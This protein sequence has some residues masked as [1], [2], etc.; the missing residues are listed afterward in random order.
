LPKRL[1]E[2]AGQRRRFGYQRLAI[3]LRREG[4]VVNLK[5]IWRL[6]RPDLTNC[7]AV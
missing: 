5:R 6:Y 7:A 1:R 4:A 2:L 3:L